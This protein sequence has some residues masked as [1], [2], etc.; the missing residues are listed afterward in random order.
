MI[1]P[2]LLAGSFRFVAAPIALPKKCYDEVGLYDESLRWGEDIDMALRLSSKFPFLFERSSTYGWRS[3]EGSSSYVM[4][5][6][7]RFRDESRVL[8]KH[9]LNNIETLDSA[10]KRQ[11]FNRLF[12]YYIGSGQWKRLLK[13]SLVDWQ[14][15]ISMA[16]VPSRMNHPSRA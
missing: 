15:F 12:E 2:Y 4:G 6:S 13:M 7:Q 11:A 3:H 5:K 10:T 9:I 16:T 8:E 14:A 1:F